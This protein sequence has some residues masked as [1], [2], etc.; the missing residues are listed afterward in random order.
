MF[1]LAI[2]S[3]LLI[4]LILLYVYLFYSLIYYYRKSFIQLNSK[5]TD[6]IPDSTLDL[7]LKNKTNYKPIKIIVVLFLLS[8]YPFAAYVLDAG[9]KFFLTELIFGILFSPFLFS[10]AYAIIF[11]FKKILNK[12]C[13]FLERC[14]FSFLL[15]FVIVFFIFFL[16]NFFLNNYLSLQLIFY[17]FNFGELIIIYFKP[18]V[19]SKFLITIIALFLSLFLIPIIIVFSFSIL[20]FAIIDLR[21]KEKKTKSIIKIVLWVVFIMILEFLIH[22]IRF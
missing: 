8:I 13:T 1:L 22:N 15:S 10:I 3:P 5:N 18:L 2:K 14:F 20:F 16:N 7:N 4:I 11:Y 21:E 17:L 12:E 6:L 9:Q 19:N